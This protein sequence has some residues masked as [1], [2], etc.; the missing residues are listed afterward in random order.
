MYHR[1][2]NPV[3]IVG[4]LVSMCTHKVGGD[5]VKLKEFAVYKSSTPT[6]RALQLCRLSIIQQ[7]VIS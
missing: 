7:S 1:Q 2:R 5:C 6:L 4:A 3:R